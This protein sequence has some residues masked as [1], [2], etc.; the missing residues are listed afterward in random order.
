M[1]SAKSL[2][3]L[4]GIRI[5]AHADTIAPTVANFNEDLESMRFLLACRQVVIELFGLDFSI[6]V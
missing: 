6:K 2:S 4:Q 1:L 5:L 3:L